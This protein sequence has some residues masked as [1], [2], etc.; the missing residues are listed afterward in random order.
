MSLT[1]QFTGALCSSDI[2]K[3]VSCFGIYAL[4]QYPALLQMRMFVWE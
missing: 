4:L 1:V 2:R 3:S